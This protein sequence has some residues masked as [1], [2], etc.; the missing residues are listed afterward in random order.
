MQG[1]RDESA[2]TPGSFHGEQ[3]QSEAREKAAMAV[4]DC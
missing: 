3:V 4:K 1:E 2:V